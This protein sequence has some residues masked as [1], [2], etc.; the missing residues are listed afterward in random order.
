MALLLL[1]LHRELSL[2]CPFPPYF[3]FADQVPF[4]NSMD[5]AGESLCSLRF[6]DQTRQIE[7]GKPVRRIMALNVA[8]GDDSTP[9]G[10]DALVV[11][12]IDGS[13]AD[14]VLDAGDGAAGAGSA[15]TAATDTPTAPT[16]PALSM[17]MGAKGPAS[18]GALKR[19][20]SQSASTSRP[21]VSGVSVASGTLSA[22]AAAMAARK[23]TKL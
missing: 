19:P 18:G 12:G 22:S 11:E 10:D 1:P 5:S 20:L 14:G 3:G 4:R 7:M 2:L 17:A 9:R 16:R 23:K 6:A 13:T 15:S 21:P 8:D